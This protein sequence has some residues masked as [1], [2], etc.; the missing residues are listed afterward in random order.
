MAFGVTKWPRGM[1]PREPQFGMRGFAWGAVPPWIWEVSTTGALAPLEYLNDGIYLSPVSITDTLVVYEFDPPDVYRFEVRMF[2]QNNS[3]P[4]QAEW[5]K[6]L[7]V[8]IYQTGSGGGFTTEKWSYPAAIR[9]FT[10][11]AVIDFPAGTVAQYLPN[12]LLL[13]PVRWDSVQ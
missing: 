6:E 7:N 11:P 12:P 3:I 5:S 2:G 13:T 10:L 8:T 1:D 9:Q 4:D